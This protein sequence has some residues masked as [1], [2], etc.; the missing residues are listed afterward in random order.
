[1]LLKQFRPTH[2]RVCKG[3]PIFQYAFRISPG[4]NFVPGKA[5]FLEVQM[6]KFWGPMI[7]SG[8]FEPLWIHHS[9]NGLYYKYQSV[10]D[11]IFMDSARFEG[12]MHLGVDTTLNGEIQEARLSLRTQ[13]KGAEIYLY[14]DWKRAA[15]ADHVCLALLPLARLL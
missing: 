10:P 4:V 12:T 7:I 15:S 3:R 2:F 13:S 5:E 6:Y 9:F 14:D 8:F 1:M 11:Q